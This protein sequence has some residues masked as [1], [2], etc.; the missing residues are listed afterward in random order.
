[1]QPLRVGIAGCGRIAQLIHL[2]ILPRLPGVKVVALA[3][4]DPLRREDARRRVP[5][6]IALEDYHELLAIPEIQAVVICLPSSQHA[7]AAVAALRQGKHVYLEKPIATSSDEAES[8]LEAWKSAG[9]VGMIG[10]N[11]RFNPL[12][13]AMR[14]AVQSDR[15]GELV[16]VRTVFSTSGR[17]LPEW[18]KRVKNGGGVLLDLASH[19]IDLVH[20]LFGQPVCEVS[21]GVWSRRSEADSATLDLRL[22]SGLPV[23]S[24]VSLDSVEEDR[25]DVYGRAGKLTVN[26]YRSLDVELSDV[27]AKLDPL[28]CIGRGLRMLRSSSHIVRKMRSPGHAPSYHA[29]LSHFVDAVRS[30]R[31]ASP[32]FS[33]GYRSLLVVK[34]AEESA[35]KGCHVWLGAHATDRSECRPGCDGVPT[36]DHTPLGSV[37]T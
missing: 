22:A 33:D 7:E 8:V 4:P 19:H 36:S 6:A 37:Q 34:A 29:A 24:F 9:A 28:R 15:L 27:D 11:Y 12:F 3:D 1:M 14:R 32:D 2:A 30:N 17:D 21:A 25:V 20:F 35:G 10:F 18:K 5:A 13:Q 23:Q 31:P 16:C 26:R